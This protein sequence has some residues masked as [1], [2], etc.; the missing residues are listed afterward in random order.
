MEKI[1]AWI[2]DDEKDAHTLIEGLIKEYCP[3]VEIIGN[4][5]NIEHAW[6]NIR[7]EKPRLI[8]LDINM[9]RGTGIDLLVRF[10]IRKFEVIVV[11]AYPENESKLGP[12]KDV[13]FLQ[14]PYSIDDF[15][16]ITEKAI[17]RIRENPHQ[18]HRY[19]H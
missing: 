3:A 6:D 5:L 15:I 12:Y 17:D 14:K 8:Y 16:N 18:I 13:P 4:S 7:K 2:I 19:K 10:P 1:K 11:S 9:P